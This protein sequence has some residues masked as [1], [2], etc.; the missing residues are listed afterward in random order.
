MEGVDIGDN[1][2]VV[3]YN[4]WHCITMRVCVLYCSNATECMVQCDAMYSSVVSCSILCDRV[5]HWYVCE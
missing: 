2:V 3:R 1:G 5:F 4:E